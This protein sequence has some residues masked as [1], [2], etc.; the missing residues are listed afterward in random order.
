MLLRSYAVVWNPNPMEFN[1]FEMLDEH[2]YSGKKIVIVEDDNEEVT[3]RFT[4]YAHHAIKIPTEGIAEQ[5]YTALKEPQHLIV[6]DGQGH[7]MS[8]VQLMV[9][10]EPVLVIGK[11]AVGHVLERGLQHLGLEYE[12]RGALTKFPKLHGD[13]YRVVGAGI[14]YLEDRTIKLFAGCRELN[15][16]SVDRDHKERMESHLGLYKFR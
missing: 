16:M 14:A 3:G 2:D 7:D 12:M 9:G 5:I 1:W 15:N 8:A 4:K 13:D 10:E 6:L 11:S